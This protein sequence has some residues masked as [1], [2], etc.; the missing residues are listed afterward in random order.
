MSR[1]GVVLFPSTS[2]VLRAEKLLIGKGVAVRLVPTPRELSSDCGV[3]LRFDWADRGVVEAMLREAGIEF[4]A[5]H[6]F[7]SA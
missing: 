6:P 3:S 7:D 4:D 2:L 1:Y 5:V